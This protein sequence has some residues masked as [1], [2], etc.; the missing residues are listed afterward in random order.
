MTVPLFGLVGGM[1]L[2]S[3]PLAPLAAQAKTTFA[4][5][6]EYKAVEVLDLQRRTWRKVFQVPVWATAL[7]V[8][9]SNDRLAFLSWT[10]R[11]PTQGDTPER[12]SELVVIDLAGKVLG[13][14]VE[15]VQRYA[16][17]G[18]DCLVFITGQREEGHLGFNPEG[19]GM[20]SLRTSQVTAMPAPRTPIGISWAPFDR[21]AYVKNWPG[22]GEAQI[23]KLDLASRTL[24]ATPLLDYKFSPTGRY[25]LYDAEMTDTLV[26]VETK[27]NV[28]VNLDR[29][30]REKIL[31]GWASPSEDVLL[32][33]NRPPRR[34]TPRDR[35]R[36]KPKELDERE[37]D[38][39]YQL[40]DVARSRMQATVKGV[41]RN[42]SAPD[43]KRLVQRGSD[44]HVIGAR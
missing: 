24:T 3:L 37:A 2:A 34:T 14:R 38:V 25:Y 1:A 6:E 9:P 31:I 20:L 22:L 42:W 21:S 41:L 15:Q 39:T 10:E 28:P 33:L 23:Y 13:P 44:F 43:N 32:T 27:T 26:V 40:Y 29:L 35:P 19:I 8:A 7:T 36:A 17:C 16:W 12:R 18:S 11:Q 4:R 30:R 5:V